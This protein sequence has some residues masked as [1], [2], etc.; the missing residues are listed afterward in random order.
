MNNMNKV[1][2]HRE[3]QLKSTLK[4]KIKRIGNWSYIETDHNADKSIDKV[5]NTF[6]KMIVNNYNE[7]V[8]TIQNDIYDTISPKSVVPTHPILYKENDI[9][10]HMIDSIVNN[11]NKIITNS[12]SVDKIF[13]YR[14]NTVN[15]T[16]CFMICK[17]PSANNYAITVIDYDNTTTLVKCT[18]NRIASYKD[19]K[20]ESYL[21]LTTPFVMSKKQRN[22]EDALY[23]DYYISYTGDGLINILYRSLKYIAD[24]ITEFQN[25]IE[26]PVIYKAESFVIRKLLDENIID[27]GIIFPVGIYQTNDWMDNDVSDNLS[28]IYKNIVEPD[29]VYPLLDLTENDLIYIRKYI[30]KIINSNRYINLTDY[31]QFPYGKI[32]R[33]NI[34]NE[35]SMVIVI[36]DSA[37]KQDMIRIIMSYEISK[38]ISYVAWVDFCDLEYFNMQN[39]SIN[40][41]VTFTGHNIQLPFSM[42]NIIT[43]IPNELKDSDFIITL[44]FDILGLNIL[45]YDKPDKYRVIEQYGKC[46]KDDLSSKSKDVIVKR[47][48]KSD[49]EAKK[50]IKSLRQS[51][52]Y[53]NHEYVME[54]WHRK[55]YYMNTKRGKVWVEPTICHRHLPLSTK[56]IHIKM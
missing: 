25:N 9:R 48:L 23:Q 12:L 51:G 26:Y 40:I 37:V 7:K 21:I 53:S 17:D 45:M 13:T 35:C 39:V 15:N 33:F 28:T 30:K 29:L 8:F 3:P 52:Q 18:V 5:I 46:N 11:I 44:A 10:S 41:G 20:L 49:K 56:E 24:H 27:K 55:G 43:L 19:D 16:Y 1:L 2:K 36:D 50:Y 14:I 31:I 6:E 34:S 22:I 38:N 42:N 32:Y 4:K 54:T 47:I